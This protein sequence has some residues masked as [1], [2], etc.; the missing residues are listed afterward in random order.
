MSKVYELRDKKKKL[1]EERIELIA[2]LKSMNQRKF[3]IDKEMLDLNKSI[4]A[5]KSQE[6]HLSDHAILRYLERVKGMDIEKIRG[7]IL[8][9]KRKK[10]I[11][12][13]ITVKIPIEK[14]HQ[15]V[16]EKCIIKTII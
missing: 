14:N 13:C 10:L 12:K 16:A 9:E 5:A 2:K 6:V 1:K 7:E 3:D 15:L 11:L 8:T 4:E